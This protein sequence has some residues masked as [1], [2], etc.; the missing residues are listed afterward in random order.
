MLGRRRLWPG[1]PA[2]NA[3]PLKQTLEVQASEWNGAHTRKRHGAAIH[4]RLSTDNQDL[5]SVTGQQADCRRQGE[6]LGF[7]EMDDLVDESITEATRLA[8]CGK[9]RR[10]NPRAFRTAHGQL[11]HNLTAH[12]PKDPRSSR[13]PAQPKPLTPFQATQHPAGQIGAGVHRRQVSLES[14]GGPRGQITGYPIRGTLVTDSRKLERSY[15]DT[16]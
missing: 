14:N 7:E 11:T 1:Q 12:C 10:P 16:S 6:M 8:H 13:E 9:P 4:A 2:I 15:R 5:M 3:L